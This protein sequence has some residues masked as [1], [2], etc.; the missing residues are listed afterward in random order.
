MTPTSDVDNMVRMRAL[1]GRRKHVD[2]P[3][4]GSGRAV[5]VQRPEHQN[6]RFCGGQRK[7]DGFQIAHLADQNDVRIPAQGRMQSGSEDRRMKADLALADQTLFA[8]VH[9]LDRILDRDDVS[10]AMDVDFV[11]ASRQAS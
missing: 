8:W 7:G 9:K 2:N 11:D 4:H 6:S 10:F 5:G 1:L 3:V